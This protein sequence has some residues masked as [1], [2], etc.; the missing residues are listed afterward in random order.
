MKLT[1]CEK[2]KRLDFNAGRDTLI[3]HQGLL[4]AARN[5]H[6]PEEL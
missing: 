3:R 5:K 4:D 1:F 6:Q 2:D